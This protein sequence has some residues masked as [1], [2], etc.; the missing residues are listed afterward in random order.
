MIEYIVTLKIAG[1]ASQYQGVWNDSGLLPMLS[2]TPPTLPKVGDSL[3]FY[4]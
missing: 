4:A 1:D 3:N 2:P